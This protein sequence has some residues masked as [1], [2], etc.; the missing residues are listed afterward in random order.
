MNQ[1]ARQ[2]GNRPPPF[3]FDVLHPATLYPLGAI[4]LAIALAGAVFPAR[5]AARSRVAAILRSE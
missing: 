1:L 5:R 3:A 4:G 2:I